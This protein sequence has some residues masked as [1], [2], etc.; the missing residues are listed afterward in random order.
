MM[1]PFVGLRLACKCEWDA[2]ASSYLSVSM[3]PDNLSVCILIPMN[4]Q[5][6]RKKN[7]VCVLNGKFVR[8]PS[9]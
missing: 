2:E 3:S 4:P 7:L 6:R 8:G 1:Y 5:Y 9:G